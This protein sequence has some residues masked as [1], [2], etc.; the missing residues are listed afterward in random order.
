MLF[1]ATVDDVCLDGYSTEAH[2]K[3]LLDFFQ[4]QDVKATF[5][6]VPRAGGVP[7]T[8]R[9]DYLPLLRRA[10]QEGH[11]IAQHGL[12]HDRFETG[13]PPQM[14]LDLPHEGPARQRLAS[15][16]EAIET[17]LQVDQ[18]RIRLALGR[19]I[20]EDALE[21]EVAG[22]RAPCLSICPNLFDALEAEGYGYDSSRFLQETGWDVINDREPF[23][24]RPITRELFEAVLY[25]G[26]MRT[27]PLTTEYSWYPTWKKFGVSMNLA[28]HDVRE[29]FKVGIPF[30]PVAH[31][32]PILEGDAGCGLEFYRQLLEYARHEAN[33]IGDSLQAVTLRDAMQ[34]V[35]VEVSQ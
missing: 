10:I 17:A 5:F 32:S 24:P 6:A 27:F 19:E 22:F 29:C 4:W 33:K 11:D 34:A 25:P 28:K 14:I 2:F 23:I 20:L 13:I 31:V 26:R 30:V 12:E 7:I 3:D 9:K 15:D 8:Q 18:I 1:C 21:H 35:G 16:R